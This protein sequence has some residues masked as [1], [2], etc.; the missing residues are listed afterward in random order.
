MLQS[1]Y[2]AHKVGIISF[3]SNRIFCH[4]REEIF[5]RIG[6]KKHFFRSVASDEGT[7][8]GENHG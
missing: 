5:E 6:F 2:F 8:S 3:Y 7:V 4:V 1:I